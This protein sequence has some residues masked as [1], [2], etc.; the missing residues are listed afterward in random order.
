V[1][2]SATTALA[3]L[4]SRP[5]KVL[6]LTAVKANRR[7][8]TIREGYFQP[9]HL[10]E[11]SLVDLVDDGG[12]WAMDDDLPI[13]RVAHRAAKTDSGLSPQMIHVGCHGVLGNEAEQAEK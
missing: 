4:A 1:S 6:Y 10:V 8:V 12:E 9:L 3:G 2:A 11:M 7:D 13:A 5:E